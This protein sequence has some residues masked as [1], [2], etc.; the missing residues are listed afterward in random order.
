[1]HLE[2]QKVF[3]W[4]WLVWLGLTWHLLK[5]SPL[6]L[7][8]QI[9]L[10]TMATDSRFPKLWIKQNADNAALMLFNSIPLPKL[11]GSNYLRTLRGRY[12]IYSIY[13][14]PSPSQAARHP[15]TCNMIT[16]SFH[17]FPELQNTI[18]SC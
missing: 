12:H 11:R 2:Q 17:H 13:S 14:L 16:F 1:M 10:Q 9:Q 15:V 4:K 18:H 5:Y 3:V 6:R 8:L 7:H